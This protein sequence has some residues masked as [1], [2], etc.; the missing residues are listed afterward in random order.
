MIKTKEER[1]HEAQ[2]EF[3]FYDDLLEQLDEAK[4]GIQES[5]AA[6]R[7]ALE[8][9]PQAHRLVLRRAEVYWISH[10]QGA[11]E[12]ESGFSGSMHTL[13]DTIEEITDEA[14]GY[15]ERLVELESQD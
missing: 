1:I 8:S 3:D 7:A 4:R 15:E 10:I 11:I 12:S 2:R 14:C 13:Q 9:L 6:A 5:L